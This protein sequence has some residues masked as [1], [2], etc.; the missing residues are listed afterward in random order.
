VPPVTT[1]SDTGPV[2]RFGKGEI[3]EQVGSLVLTFIAGVKGRSHGGSSQVVTVINR[4]KVSL[5]VRRASRRFYLCN[6][7]EAAITDPQAQR[8]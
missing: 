8:D 3:H 7:G 4:R 1:S 5:A 2:R 6:S